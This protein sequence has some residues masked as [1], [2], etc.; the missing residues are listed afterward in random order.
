MVMAE[1]RRISDLMARVI[2]GDPWHAGNVMDLLADLTVAE[3]KAHPVRGGHSIWEIVLHLTG[4]ANEVCARVE[5]KAAGTPG[6][7][8]WPAVGSATAARWSSAKEGLAR[9]YQ[10][11]SYVVS[12]LP[13]RDLNQPVLDRRNNALGTGLSRYLTIHG[14]IHHGVY[15]AGQMALLKRALR[16]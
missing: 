4:W 1:T 9:A 10:H 2:D 14:A 13:D 11:H 12:A 15:H 6:R 3:A 5:G 16:S 8:D 7:G